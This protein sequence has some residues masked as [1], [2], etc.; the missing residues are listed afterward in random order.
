LLLNQKL[1]AGLGNIYVDESL[2][3]AK[4]SPQRIAGKIKEQEAKKLFREINRIISQAIKSR[5]TTFNNYV[6]SSGR[7]GQFSLKLKAYGRKG[8]PCFYCKKPIIRIKL[9]GRG[10]HY[11]QNCQK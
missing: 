6:D 11:C 5:G 4:I 3:A 9:A 2:F 1:I 7:K 10:T 8:L